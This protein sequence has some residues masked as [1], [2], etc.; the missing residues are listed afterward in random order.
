MATFAPPVRRGDFFYSSVLYADPGNG[1][2]HTRASI[3]ELAALLRPA[4]PNVNFNIGKRPPTTPA[5]DPVWHWYAAQLIHYGLPGTKDKNVAKV[6][7]LNALN[8]FKLEVPAWIL[9][10]EGE[11]RKEWE[12]ENRKIKKAATGR[13]PNAKTGKAAN[14]AG[15]GTQMLPLSQGM[16]VN[17]NVSIGADIPMLDQL[18][19]AQVGNTGQKV[20]RKRGMDEPACDK[21]TPKKSVKTTSTRKAANA[22]QAMLTPDPRPAVPPN[23]SQVKANIPRIKQEPGA[24]RSSPVTSRI[25]RESNP[26]GVAVSTPKTKQTASKR[27]ASHYGTEAV[28]TSSPYFSSL[29]EQESGLTDVSAPKRR[30]KQTARKSAGG[31]APTSTWLIERGPNGTIVVSGTYELSVDNERAYMVIRRDAARDIWWS[32]INAGALSFTIKMDPGPTPTALYQPFS[33]GW[34]M[35]ND[36]T[37]ELKFGSGCTGEFRFIEGASGDMTGVLRNVPGLGDLEFYG[38]RMAGSPQTGDLQTEWDAF[39]RDA[40]GR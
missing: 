17:V 29:T 12:G 5:K 40:Y 30:T 3:A 24:A 31:R 25:K 32:T 35:R 19:L 13:V 11:L 37:G 15:S 20:K 33:V 2:H 22:A 7:L 28:P 26:A 18:G 1:N 9:K 21:P 27:A 4:A 10:L 34:R 8:Q 6:R 23:P 39:R 36:D 14:A 38:G 16:N